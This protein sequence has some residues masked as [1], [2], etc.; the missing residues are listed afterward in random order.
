MPFGELLDQ[1]E[2][3][4]QYSGQVKRKTEVYIDDI[5]PFGI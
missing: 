1:W 3:H 4:R 2:V 5:I